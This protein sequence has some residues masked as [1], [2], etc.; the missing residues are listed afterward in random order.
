MSDDIRQILE[1]WN[2]DSTKNLTVRLIN[3]DDGKTR[4]QMRIDMGLIQMELDGNPSGE[5]TE[6][7]ES[8][9]EYFEHEQK[10]YESSNVDDYFSLSSDEFKKLHREGVQYYYRYLSLMELEDFERVVRDTDRNLRLFAFVKK[11]AASEMDRW[12][13]DQ[14]RPYVIMMNARAKAALIL[15][16]D[17]EDG[18]NKAIEFFDFGVGNIIDFYNEYGL[19]SEIDNSIE[20]SILKALKTEFLSKSPETFQEKLQKAI[21]EERFEDAAMI[22][23]E[24]RKKNKNHTD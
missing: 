22:R 8:W 2:Y 9:L 1:N 13:L 7:F 10:Q 19:S 6:G 3:G 17:P 23:D 14:F 15:R 24:I 4:I 18:I 21:R 5:K 12:A 11:Y 16:E 20:L